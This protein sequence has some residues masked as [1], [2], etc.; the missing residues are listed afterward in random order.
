[1]TE[2]RAKRVTHAQSPYIT[3]GACKLFNSRAIA[4]AP[5]LESLFSSPRSFSFPLHLSLRVPGAGPR[6]IKAQLERGKKT[7]TGRNASVVLDSI[8][9]LSSF[10]ILSPLSF[11]FNRRGY[12]RFHQ[13][14]PFL[15][16]N[17]PSSSFPAKLFQPLPREALPVPGLCPGLGGKRVGLA[18]IPENAWESFASS[19]YLKFPF[20][21]PRATGNFI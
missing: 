3:V 2:L 11:H 19:N 4:R 13:L 10:N 12:L 15:F 14:S 7:M 6:I 16:R 20:D 1:M 18:I 8:S 9:S 5:T 17:A 21:V